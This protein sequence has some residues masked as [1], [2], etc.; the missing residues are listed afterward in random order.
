MVHFKSFLA[1]CGLFAITPTVFSFLPAQAS[2]TSSLEV[3]LNGLK[4]ANGR[5]CFTIFSGPK[6]FPAGG[7]GANLVTSR[8]VAV[9]DQ[10]SHITFTNLPLGNYAIAVIHDSN[11]D[12]RLNTNPL[13]VP[14]EGF[15]F[16]NN[17]PLRFGPAKFSESQVFVSGNK[18]V[19]K[20]QMRYLN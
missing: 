4:N 14:K 2:Y 1:L 16:S 19:V 15:G 7:Q 3:K 20:I 11:S 6:G 18:T 13:G 5:V 12:G 17:P 10:G 9:T 8:C